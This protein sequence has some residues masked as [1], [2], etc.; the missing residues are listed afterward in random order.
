LATYTALTGLQV[1]QILACYSI[2]VHE[3][4]PLS[5]GAAN[6]SFLIQTDSVPYVLTVLDNHDQ[7]SADQLVALLEHLA[8]YGIPTSRPLRTSD[9]RTFASFVSKPVLVKE[10]VRGRCDGALPVEQ[11]AAAGRLLGQVHAVPAPNWL[12]E[13]GRRLPAD[14]ARR[15]SEFQD[16]EFAAWLRDQWTRALDFEQIN[17]PRGLVHG[18]YF[19]DNLVVCLDG[20]LTVLD[21][22]TAS[23][24]HL[25]LDIGMAIVGLCRTDG[26]FLPDRAA[27]LVSG[28]RQ[29]RAMT[30][31]E[32]EHLQD[33][34]RY[35]SLI[36]AYHRY[37]RHHITHPDPAKQ[38]LY[39]EMP[40][41]VD[42]IDKN[43]QPW[44]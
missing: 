42:S 37:L 40:Q 38:H 7:R 18:D 20:R 10:Y 15:L 25:L 43:W 33:A 14:A 39:L 19:A 23:H 44:T 17:V 27:M 8:G 1:Q 41:F 35:A 13:N 9:G 26:R 28:Y 2:S 21:W 30:P 4:Q 31:A 32:I 11:Y 34:V 24:D 12:P 6:S 22:E 36:I 29:S 3:S 16:R 5:G